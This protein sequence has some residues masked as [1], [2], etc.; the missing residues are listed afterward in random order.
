MSLHL[1]DLPRCH[2]PWT[3]R[4]LYESRWSWKW[5]IQKSLQGGVVAPGDTPVSGIRSSRGT[6][7]PAVRPRPGGPSPG[8][9]GACLCAWAVTTPGLSPPA[10]TRQARGRPASLICP[11]W[12]S[13]G[14]SPASGLPDYLS[15]KGYTLRCL[16][17]SSSCPFLAKMET[18]HPCPAP[19][20]YLWRFSDK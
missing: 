15:L 4:I 7:S 19:A 13:P 3:P 18:S 9:G 12:I 1:I 5:N 14:A 8:K 2:L 16:A 11:R 6:S 20:Q 10:G 17:L